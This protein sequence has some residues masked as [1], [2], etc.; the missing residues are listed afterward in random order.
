MTKLANNLFFVHIPKTAGTAIEHSFGIGVSSV[1]PNN[2]LHRWDSLFPKLKRLPGR[3]GFQSS[4]CS[5]NYPRDG[6]HGWLSLSVCAHHLTL[7]ETFWLGLLASKDLSSYTFFSV[8]RH[9][10]DRFISSWRSHHRYVKYPD[11]NLYLNYVLGCRSDLLGHDDL[12]HTRRM[13]DYLSTESLPSGISLRILR[14]ENL[15]REWL[16]LGGDLISAGV[17]SEGYSWPTLAKKGVS[18]NKYSTVPFSDA[19]LRRIEE[20]YR[21]DGEQYGYDMSFNILRE[22]ASSSGF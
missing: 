17:F 18:P 20:F 14:F 11:I 15:A 16:K 4:Y 19:S 3:L 13:A 1:E 22:M 12:S 2:R 5:G 7:A 6:L 10:L 21:L 8:V 9:P